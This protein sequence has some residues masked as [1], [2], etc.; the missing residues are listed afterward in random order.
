MEHVEELALAFFREVV[1][2]TVR[3]FLADPADKRRG[4]LACLALAGMTEHYFHASS[5]LAQGGKPRLT[6]LKG[7][8]RRENAAIGWIADVANATK[9]VERP[10]KR[11][12]RIGYGDVATLVTNQCGVIRAGWPL[13]GKEVVV[14]SECEWLLS[15]LV[16]ETMRFWRGKLNLVAPGDVPAY[17]A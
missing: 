5:D 1:E 12:N 7:E 3:E 10:E 4:C 6:A 15:E 17:P 2:P 9:H 11:G 8:L 16:G 14:G 13:G